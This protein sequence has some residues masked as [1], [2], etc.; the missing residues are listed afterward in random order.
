MTTI[1][2]QLATS[3]EPRIIVRDEMDVR[4]LIAALSLYSAHETQETL[5]RTAESL[6]D[7]LM[8]AP[9]GVGYSSRL[10]PP[11]TGASI[12]ERH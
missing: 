7:A 9:S 2:H 6:R 10:A 1:P 11:V 3:D 4:I 5:A 8:V 12:P